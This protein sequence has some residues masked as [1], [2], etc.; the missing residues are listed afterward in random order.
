[1]QEHNTLI[2]PRTIYMTWKTL[3]L[4]KFMNET[5]NK[6]QQ[7]NNEFEIKIYDDNMC[8][9]FIKNNFDRDILIAYDNLIP[10]AYKA[11]LWRLCI[12]YK[13]GGIYIDIKFEPVNNFKL[14]NLINRNILTKDLN[15]SHI[16]NGFIIS[17]SNNIFLKKCIYKIVYNV[18]IH[19]YGD[20]YLDIT[21]PSMIGRLF[22]NTYNYNLDVHLQVRK[23]NINGLITNHHMICYNDTIILQEYELYRHEQDYINIHYS[24]AW[25][26]RQVFIKK[27]IIDSTNNKMSKSRII[28]KFIHIKQ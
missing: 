25:K 17:E 16:Y 8:R 7:I 19:Y 10:G 22:N 3:N 5:I 21:G 23:K 18:N 13:Y 24:I 14:I 12:L 20:N 15:D 28:K 1:M 4:P 9:E 11:D 2:I 26:N 27:E 6:L